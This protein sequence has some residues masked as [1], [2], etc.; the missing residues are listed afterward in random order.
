MMISNHGEKIKALLNKIGTGEDLHKKIIEI[1]TLS[2]ESKGTSKEYTFLIG[3]DENKPLCLK[4]KSEGKTTNSSF[5]NL[6]K[7]K[8]VISNG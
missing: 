3:K 7:L 1:E 4:V 5:D 6:D 2:R 8:K